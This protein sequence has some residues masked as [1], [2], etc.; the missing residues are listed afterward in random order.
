MDSTNRIEYRN[1]TPNIRSDFGVEGWAMAP[2]ECR[3]P[4]TFVFLMPLFDIYVE[5]RLQFF[6]DHQW[7][8][9]IYPDCAFA[10]VVIGGDCCSTFLSVMSYFFEKLGHAEV[11]PPV[12]S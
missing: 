10:P 11:V 5:G 7:V 6:D 1:P 12:R 8:M 4:A 3:Q 2:L 9:T